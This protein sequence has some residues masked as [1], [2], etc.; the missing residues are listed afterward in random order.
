MSEDAALDEALK[1][2]H[3]P[4]L[5]LA[6]VHLTG[7]ASHLKDAP[8]I[9][10]DP[11]GDGQG[12]LPPAWQEAM[13]TK[14]REAWRAWKAGKP[15]AAQPDQATLRRM[16]DTIAG[17]P[18]PE[19]Y[20]PFLLE[21]LAMDGVDPKRPAPI[22]PKLK[23]SGRKLKV[24]IIGAGMSARGRKGQTAPGRQPI[25]V[26]ISS[27]VQMEGL[28]PSAALTAL[29]SSRPSLWVSSR[30]K[31]PSLNLRKRVLLNSACQPRRALTRSSVA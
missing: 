29:L 22:A 4:T 28:A 17:M 25:S 23:A 18:I 16:M 1:A 9:V 11:L 31:R 26:C 19:H 7:D 8:P 12:G 20:V 2:A 24:L 13:H 14:A 6:L 10:Y 15:L 27:A 3:I 30:A 5:M 21:E